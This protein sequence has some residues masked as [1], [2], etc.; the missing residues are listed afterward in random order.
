MHRQWGADVVGMTACP[1]ARLVREAEMSYALIALPTDYDCWKPRL[2]GG[3]EQSLLAEIVGN[4][5]R[6][7]EASFDL[8]TAALGDCTTL[9]DKKSP[10][11]QALAASIWSTKELID[12]GEIERLRPLWGRWF[13]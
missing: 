8:L 10:A 5:R 9:R 1:E 3:D 2:P 13:S 7:T 12:E 4:L 6:A 11:H